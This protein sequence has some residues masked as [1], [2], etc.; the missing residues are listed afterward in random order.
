MWNGRFS[1]SIQ[2]LHFKLEQWPIIREL[3]GH[4]VEE[5]LRTAYCLP[6]KPWN[7]S[8]K[9]PLLRMSEACVSM[10][11]RSTS[12]FRPRSDTSMLG[13]TSD[14]RFIL[15][16][17]LFRSSLAW[18]PLHRA[19]MPDCEKEN[20]LAHLIT[21]TFFIST[22]WMVLLFPMSPVTLHLSPCLKLHFTISV[23]FSSITSWYHHFFSTFAVNVV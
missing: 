5:C 1:R 3:S 23:P 2:N 20:E 21:S 10:N 17:L 19:L 11:H 22:V 12:S 9:L 18:S 6:A 13:L 16:A 14:C 7:Q 15:Q 8:G 4:P